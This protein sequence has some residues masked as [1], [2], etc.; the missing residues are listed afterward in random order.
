[1]RYAGRIS[2][3]SSS[4]V[5]EFSFL[6]PLPAL[7]NVVETI[8]DIDIPEA[9]RA[10]TLT[11]KV[12]PGVSPTLC[13]HFRAATAFTLPAP[14]GSQQRVT[15]IQ[16]SAITLRPMGPLGAV[17]VHFKPEAIHRLLG[18]DMEEFTDAHVQLRDLFSLGTLSVLD[19]RVQQA[20]G[21]GARAARV[22][23]FLLQHLRHD[24]WDSLVHHAVEKLRSQPGAPIRQ[25]ADNLHISQ[26]QL[27][28]RFRSII[29]TNL[30]QFARTARLGKAI[31]ARRRGR[32]WTE[33]AHGVG[34]SDQAHLGHDFK[35]MTGH[36]PE[37]LFQAASASE[38]RC[39]DA[40]LAASGF[41]NTLIV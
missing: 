17:I 37:A 1:M 5:P 13:V 35:C 28:R 9:D 3:E 38:N 34:F 11:L 12:L 39:L 27:S 23:E 26:K 32:S 10:R 41:F 25:L 19:E 29:G 36:A 6:Q 16:T 7:A 24:P 22:Q 8:W 20:A 2:C 40:S 21:P 30:K 31:L 14:V 33:I 4:T 15:G 18:C